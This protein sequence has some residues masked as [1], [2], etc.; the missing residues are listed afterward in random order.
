[1]QSVRLWSETAVAVHGFPFIHGAVAGSAVM[2]ALI[3]ARYPRHPI[4]WLLSAVGT[5][6]AVSLVTEAY[7]YWV[8]ESDGPGSASLGGVA[9]WV[10][11]LFGGRIS[12]AAIALM[13]LLAPDGHLLS[14][15]WR[16]AAWVTDFGA[17]LCM[18][19]V[20]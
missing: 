19:A 2:G 12:V 20:L 7:A 1:A 6:G 9:A 10:S 5:M 15:R 14:R 16:Y 18:V 8:Q 13:S 4:G 17:L 11:T 3:V